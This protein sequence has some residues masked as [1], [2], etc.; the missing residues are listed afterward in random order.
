[1]VRINEALF[2]ILMLKCFA[3]RGVSTFLGQPAEN[4]A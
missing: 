4:L 3:A 2:R 1:M